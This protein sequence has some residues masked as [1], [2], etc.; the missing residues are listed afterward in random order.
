MGEISR[1]AGLEDYA[2]QTTPAQA[3]EQRVGIVGTKWEQNQEIIRM[4]VKRRELRTHFLF[5]PWDGI[6]V[7]RCVWAGRKADEFCSLIQLFL[8][9]TLY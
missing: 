2:M 4:G 9:R 3:G 5:G 7:C 6:S 1:R 8:H